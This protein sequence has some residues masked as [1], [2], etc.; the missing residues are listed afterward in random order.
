MW[1][2]RY[3]NH[4]VPRKCMP[5]AKINEMKIRSKSKNQT[6]KLLRKKCTAEFRTPAEIQNCTNS[7]T[8]RKKKSKKEP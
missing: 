7:Q 1:P 6:A 2:K 4:I 5:K 3:T 8:E